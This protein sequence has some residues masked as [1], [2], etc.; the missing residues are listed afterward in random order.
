MSANPGR[1]LW[2]YVRGAL[3]AA[4][5]V[6]AFF[7]ADRTDY[8]GLSLSQ[9]TLGAFAFGALA[10]L[11]LIGLQAF[12]P[13]SDPVWTYPRWTAYPFSSRQPLQFFH[14]GGYFVLASGAGGLLHSMFGG[15]A[16]P[17]EPVGLASWGAGILIGVWCCTRVFK[18]KMERPELTPDG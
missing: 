11:L 16:L 6:G 7:S 9:L 8:F 18:R 13:R 14:M 2:L 4:G 17:P 10:M 5:F 1:N 3:I 12:N 15:R